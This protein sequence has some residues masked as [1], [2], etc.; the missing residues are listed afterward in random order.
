M[1]SDDDDSTGESNGVVNKRAKLGVGERD[2]VTPAGRS[3]E[4]RE[5]LRAL[6]QCVTDLD[7]HDTAATLVRET[8]VASIHDPAVTALEVAI[9]AGDWVEAIRLVAQLGVEAA[10]LHAIRATLSEQLFFAQVIKGDTAN[11]LLGLRLVLQFL[12][13][14]KRLQSLAW[15]EGAVVW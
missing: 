8:G 9:I 6:L 13:P 15:C 10:A 1:E 14:L 12:V 5:L 11:A 2:V 7:L 3:L 4:R